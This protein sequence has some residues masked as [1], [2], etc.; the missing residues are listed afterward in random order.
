MCDHDGWE[1]GSREGFGENIGNIV[2]GA[3]S[4]DG[5]LMV[6]DQIM[7]GVVFDMYVFD[8]RVPDVIFCQV[9][10]GIIIAV[11]GHRT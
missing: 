11:E 10:G 1:V 8:L 2:T 9:A 5:K 3:H 7:D 6:G 4:G